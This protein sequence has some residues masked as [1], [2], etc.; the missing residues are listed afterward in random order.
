LFYSTSFQ[1]DAVE[2]EFGEQTIH[3]ISMLSAFRKRQKELLQV[4]L[5]DL[6]FQGFFLAVSLNFC[7]IYY[8]CIELDNIEAPTN[9]ANFTADLFPRGGHVDLA[10]NTA[11]EAS[12]AEQ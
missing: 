3:L 9:F 10:W 7:V 4:R 1:W 5:H 6:L 2:S 8:F 11:Q 12:L